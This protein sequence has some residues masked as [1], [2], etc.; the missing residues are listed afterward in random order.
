LNVV[1]N[2]MNK[3]SFQCRQRQSICCQEQIQIRL[4]WIAFLKL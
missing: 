4:Q 2:A 1:E 3:R